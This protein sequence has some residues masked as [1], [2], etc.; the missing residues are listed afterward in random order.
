MTDAP[1]PFS[2][3]V[4]AAIARHMNDDHAD[5]NVTI[6]RGLA[7]VANATAATMTTMTPEGIVFA[8]SDGEGATTEVVVAWSEPITERTQVRSEVVRMHTEAAAALGKAPREH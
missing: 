7:G 1:S 6:V 2:P 4:V 3:E 5:D 8:V